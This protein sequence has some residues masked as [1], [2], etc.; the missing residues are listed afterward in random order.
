MALCPIPSAQEKW[1]ESP[2]LL[3]SQVLEGHSSGV[4]MTLW[5]PLSPLGE[6]DTQHWTNTLF[7]KLI[8]QL[9]LQTKT[10]MER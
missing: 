7:F 6:P 2:F 8:L 4:A 10:N 5:T 9:S 1:R 3:E